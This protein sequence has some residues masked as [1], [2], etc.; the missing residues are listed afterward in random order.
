MRTIRRAAVLGAGVMGA[1]ISALLVNAGI[2]CL[3]LDL[4][5]TSLTA[6]EAKRGLTLSN[7]IVR[8]RLSLGAR[9]GLLTMRPAPLYDE[10]AA[11]LI[12]CGNF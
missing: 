3:L 2:P 4:A 7:G 6:D 5:P 9:R 10:E 8:N 11:S 1:Q 12:T